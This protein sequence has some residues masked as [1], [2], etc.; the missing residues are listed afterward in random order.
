MIA[1]AGWVLTLGHPVNRTIP[2]L[3]TA[4]ARN[5]TALDKSGSIAQCRGA[6]GPGATRHRFAWV[7]ST[8]TLASRSID[9]GI[10]TCGADGTDSPVG[11]IV[12]P[13]ADAAPGR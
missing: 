3:T 2:P 7:S 4:A 8:S 5:G 1:S 10:A 13:P 9:T 12:S 11:T 6:I